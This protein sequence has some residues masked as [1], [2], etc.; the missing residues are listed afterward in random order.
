M[1]EKAREKEP[2]HG[3][4]KF[5]TS[6]IAEVR[7]KVGKYAAENG[8]AKAQRYFKELKLSE[9]TV[10]YFRERYLK[11]LAQRAKAGDLTEVM[12]LG[13]VKRG[14]KLAFG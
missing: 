8:I 1:V 2:I 11:E 5:T 3:R 12:Q 13:V 14:R 10:R 4:C 6:F 9:S 7:A